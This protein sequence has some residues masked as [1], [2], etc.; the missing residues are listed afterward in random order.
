M[1]YSAHEP[2][3]AYIMGSIVGTIL[4][5]FIAYGIGYLVIRVVRKRKPTAKEKKTIIIVAA[6][7]TVLAVLAKV[8]RAVSGPLN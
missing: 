2:S 8:G 6:V 3:V 7:L 1:N 5:P 4:F